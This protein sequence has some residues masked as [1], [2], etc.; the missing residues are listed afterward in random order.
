MEASCS[1]IPYQSTGYFSKLV[2]DYLEDKDTVKPFYKHPVSKKGIIAAIEERKNF[3]TPRSLLVEELKLQYEGIELTQLQKENLEKLLDEKTFTV[4][5]AHQPNIFTGHLYFI[6]KILHTI[7]LAQSLSA[8]LKEYNFVPFFYMG[9]EDAD[10]EE[11]GHINLNGQKLEW[12]TNQTGAVGRMKVD[13]ALIELIERISGEI[14]VLEHGTEVIELFRLSYRIGVTIQQ[15]TLEVVNALFKNYGLLILIPDNANL[16]RAFNNVVKKEL[17]EAFSHPLVEE[18]TAQLGAHYKVQASGREINLFYLVDGVRERIRKDES[19]YWV[20]YF[21]WSEDEILKEV[22]EYPERFSANVILRGVFQETILPNVAFIGGGGE[23]AY[24]LELKKVF[25]ATCVPF[26]VL[27]LRNS[28]LIHTKKQRENIEKL[29]FSV[30]DFFSDERTLLECLVKKNSE[31]RLTLE[32]EQKQMEDYYLQIGNAAS[33]ID[34][35]LQPHVLALHKQAQKK[36]LEL[37]KKMLRAEKKKYE[38][39]LRQVIKLK[40]QLFPKNNLQ[41]RVDNFA[42]HYAK[43]GS[44]WIEAICDASLTLE[45]QFA[46]LEIDR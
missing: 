46:I 35:S 19:G 21:N 2:I 15:A 7:K 8:E 29:G 18:T 4:C 11:L 5:T 44:A 6:Y 28:F 32:D 1:Y 13:K 16:K 3:D 45:Q 22:D 31:L 40:E 36:L 42:P 14:S 43:Y 37:E 17:V 26:P 10:L 20:S 12:K 27:L 41:E 39:Q 30:T 23:L 38:A 25:E 9:S 34:V 33:L 24:W